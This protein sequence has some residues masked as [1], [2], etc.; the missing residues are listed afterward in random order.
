MAILVV[1]D[2]GTYRTATV[3][4]LTAFGFTNILTANDGAEGLAQLQKHGKKIGLIISDVDMP[5]MD[6]LKLLEQIR[7]NRSG[8]D[9]AYSPTVPVVIATAE[10]SGEREH[11]ALQLDAGYV[12]KPWTRETLAPAIAAAV[13]YSE[14]TK[15]REMAVDRSLRERR[16]PGR[17]PGCV[18]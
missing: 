3:K 14:E 2:S 8:A 13:D 9:I 4:A 17:S 10:G 5:T 7:Y 1:D 16:R 6:G 15:R 11:A 12:N 18:I